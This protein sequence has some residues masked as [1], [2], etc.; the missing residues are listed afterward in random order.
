MNSFCP[1]SPI[2]EVRWNANSRQSSSYLEVKH[3]LCDGPFDQGLSIQGYVPV[4][5]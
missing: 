3:R 2:L 4:L 5:S 1:R